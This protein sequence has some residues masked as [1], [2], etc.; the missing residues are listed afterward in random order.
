MS[1]TVNVLLVI[2]A[3]HLGSERAVGGSRSPSGGSSAL[4]GV[5][6]DSNVGMLDN[7]T[8]AQKNCGIT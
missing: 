6:D 8:A 2:C 7:L 5:R 1:I 4:S 3:F